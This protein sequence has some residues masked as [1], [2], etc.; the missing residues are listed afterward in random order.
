MLYARKGVGKSALAY[1]IAARVVAQGFSEKPVPLLP[2]KWWTVPKGCYKVLYLDF[3]NMGEMEKKK[4]LF[5]EGYF[6]A[7]K[8]DECRANLLMEDLSQSGIDF[9]APENHQKLLDMLED[10]R[11]KGFPDKP[12][13]LLVIDT[14]TA[15]VHAESPATP[16]NFKDLVNKIRNMGIAVLIVH[17]ANSENEARGFAT[18]MDALFLTVNMSCST[19]KSEGDLDEQP[20]IITYENPRGPMSTKLREPFEILF[21]NEKKHWNLGGKHRDE[22]K[23]LALIVEAYKKHEY[24][25]DAICQMLGLKKSALSD[26]LKRAK[27]IE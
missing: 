18:K 7:G 6:P 22:N 21:D 13:D 23:E 17:H 3:E 20:R 10:A 15:F 4:K 8:E 14:Y 27:E 12:V 19:G 26:R 1:S 16:A 5:Q 24:G 25:R 9:S 11:K 2:G